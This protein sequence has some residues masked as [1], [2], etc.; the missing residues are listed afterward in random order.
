MMGELF[1][2]AQA[3]HTRD[4][5]ERVEAAKEIIEQRAIDCAVID[6]VL[7]RY[8]RAADRDQV[9]VTLGVVIV[10]ELIEKLTTV[11]GVWVIL[12]IN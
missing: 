1:R 12:S 9:L 11:V 2:S 3:N 6:L 4:P 10:E 8:Q 7:E 5:L